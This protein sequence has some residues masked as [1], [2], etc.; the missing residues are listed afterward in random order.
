[1]KSLR[2]H[3]KLK[4]TRTRRTHRRSRQPIRGGTLAVPRASIVSKNG[5]LM[6]LEDALEIGQ[7]VVGMGVL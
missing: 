7:P 3:R 2:N 5:V 4:R 1:M 6:S